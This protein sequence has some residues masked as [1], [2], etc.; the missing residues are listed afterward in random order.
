MNTDHL[1]FGDYYDNLAIYSLALSRRDQRDDV[2]ARTMLQRLR[3]H[4]RNTQ[5]AKSL[6]GLLPDVEKSLAQLLS[7]PKPISQMFILSS[8]H[9]G[10][11]VRE[12]S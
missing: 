9:A 8:P 2:T 6:A 1:C 7:H 4:I 3:D 12:A 10:Q 11:L 5:E